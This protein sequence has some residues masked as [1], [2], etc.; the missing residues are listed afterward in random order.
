MSAAGTTTWWR[1]LAASR[2]PDEEIGGSENPYMRRWWLF[3]SRFGN[4]YLHQFLRSD[5]E[6]ALH[7]HPW[8]SISFLLEG[9]Y[10]EWSPAPHIAGHAPITP[11]YQTR[12]FL[13]PCTIIR[14]AED[15]HRIELPHG[16]ACW[17]L[18]ITGRRI[19]ECGFQ[20]PHSS[21]AGG[22]RHWREFTNPADGGATVGRGCD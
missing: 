2:P 10:R 1:R 3:R 13:A 17:T 19:R 21:P 11:Q 4:V 7:D 8:R 20:C 12:D 5:D 16:R 18:F 14:G 9:Y 22:W 6:R 15:L